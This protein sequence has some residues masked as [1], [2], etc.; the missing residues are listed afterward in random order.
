[1]SE[2]RLPKLANVAAA[3]G[4][5]AVSGAIA[6]QWKKE[7]DRRGA[8]ARDFAKDFVDQEKMLAGLM[9][10]RGELVVRGQADRL[11]RLGGDLQEVIG[12]VRKRSPIQ[13]GKDYVEY[14]RDVGERSVLFTDVMRRRG[15]Q[16]LEHMEDGQP[17]V[18]SY[19]YEVIVDG[20]ELERPVNYKLLR[21]IPPEGTPPAEET[22]RPWIIIDPRAG[23]GAGIG[24]FKTESQ[25]GVA[26]AEGFPVYFV[27]FE[28][29]PE[30]GQTLNDVMRAEAQFVREVSRRHPRAPRPIVIG[31]CQGGWATMLLAAANPTLTGAVVLNG[32]PLSYWAG[33]MG[34]N[35]MRYLGG[36]LG[37][38]LPALVYSDLGAGVFDGAN[39][40]HN[41]EALNPGRTW[42]RKYTDLFENV[43]RGAERF[44]GFERW[45]SGFFFM[46]EEEIRWIVENL[47]VGNKLARGEARLG[48]RT[49]DL[50]SIKSPILVFASQGDN[51]TPP[52]QALNWLA[53]VYASE[54]E[55]R[56]LGQKIV[57][58]VHEDVGHLGIFV[59][60]KVARR[61]HAEIADTMEVIDVLPPGLYEMVLDETRDPEGGERTEGEGR[62]VSIEPR[63]LADVL[64]M[65]DGREDEDT[66]VPVAKM[67][68]TLIGAYEL[69]ARPFV[70]AMVT[71]GFADAMV[72]SHPMR[73]Q[74][75]A[76][77]DRNPLMAPVSSLA[78]L[79]KGRRK[80][81]SEE[82]PFLAVER[83]SA[84][85]VESNLDLFR[86]VRDTFVELGFYGV[87]AS[88]WFRDIHGQHSGAEENRLHPEELEITLRES[89]EVL[90]A[91][92]NIE[93]GGYASALVRMLV[94]IADSSDQI[95]RTR[96]ERTEE[97]LR[98]TEPFASIGPRIR[99]RILREQTLLC[100]F[101]PE[102]ALAT[103]PRLL[104]ERPERERAYH[105][106]IEVAGPVEEMSDAIRGRLARI[107]DVLGLD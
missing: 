24:G 43:D 34:K 95:R 47:F 58:M 17:P 40:V 27:V 61:E 74:R 57:Y 4:P 70:R 29:K 20:H 71:Q 7:A 98:T 1:M 32:A 59:S 83:L 81:A 44:L 10:Q 26:L 8:R 84:D 63:T 62:F 31:N 21:I 50:K 99:N 2:P 76:F 96:L 78:K 33:E 105:T 67:S 5:R 19:D 30:P 90:R 28:T 53:D 92:E 35:P 87:W 36:L 60:S 106:L 55:I 69:F 38:A 46:N 64:G 88:P 49:V 100:E 25:V 73:T 6:G 86:D 94:L 101:E 85:L 93:S 39:L 3:F 37:G 48:S 91:I 66:F 102:A 14:V 89:P 97:L 79:V 80:Q 51:I 56:A 45:W 54:D 12:R 11:Q 68:E 41:F 23:H 52:Q 15:N 75:L 18:L 107:H 103:L 77:S 13:L 16:Y 104:P 65:D 9:R 72:A 22:A 82:N 42:W